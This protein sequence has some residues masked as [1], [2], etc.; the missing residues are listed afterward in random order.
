MQDEIVETFPEDGID[1]TPSLIHPILEALHNNHEQERAI[2]LFRD[3]RAR[4]ILASP[5]TFNFMLNVCIYCNEAE[6]A[7]RILQDFRDTYGADQA[8]EHYWWVILDC[9]SRNGFVFSCM[10]WLIVVGG[11]IVFLA[12]LAGLTSGDSRRV[13]SPGPFMCSATWSTGTCNRRDQH[14][15]EVRN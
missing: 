14:I 1:L 10:V 12:V 5:R 4:G 3:I 13:E 8:I 15:I 6:E 2:F 11:D 7:F 9:A